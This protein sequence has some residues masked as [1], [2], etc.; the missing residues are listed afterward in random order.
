MK[1]IRNGFVSML[2]YFVFVPVY[3]LSVSLSLTLKNHV[4]IL[5]SGLNEVKQA[6][7]LVYEVLRL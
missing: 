7:V 2:W 3:A 5:E 1:P 4:R 6:V